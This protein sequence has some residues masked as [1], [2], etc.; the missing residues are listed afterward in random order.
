MGYGAPTA[1]TYGANTADAPYGDAPPGSYGGGADKPKV[2]TETPQKAYYTFSDSLISNVT[3]A[4]AKNYLRFV[5][6]GG[7]ASHADNGSF[8]YGAKKVRTSYKEKSIFDRPMCSAQVLVKN[9]NDQN[10]GCIQSIDFLCHGGPLALYFVISQ[11][12]DGTAFHTPMDLAYTFS[13][14]YIDK[15]NKE[16]YTKEFGVE[17]FGKLEKSIAAYL[18]KMA[19]CN[20]YSTSTTES[21][22]PTYTNLIELKANPTRL[23]EANLEDIEFA[24]FT[25]AA[26]VEIHGCRTAE[27][28]P[29]VGSLCGEWSER[30]YNADKT[31]AVVI[32]HNEKNSPDAKNDYRHGVRICFHNGTI[33]FRY[34][35]DGVISKELIDKYLD[36][37]EKNL[38]DDYYP[39]IKGGNETKIPR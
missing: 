19:V 32:G 26:K 29:V 4:T 7:A 30:L 35:D 39:K 36:E 17:R 21:W 10:D 3:T 31:R 23:F 6:W 2:K 28:Y 11:L 24:K 15:K 12:D 13:S 22:A 27:T 9:I 37:K 20:L 25:S 5:F 33:L 14:K 34:D 8:Y 38:W 16:K 18:A 1:A